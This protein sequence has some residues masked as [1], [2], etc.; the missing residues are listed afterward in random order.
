MEKDVS[1]RPTSC[2]SHRQ[3]M[4]ILDDTFGFVFVFS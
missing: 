1:G 2:F 3:L 4:R